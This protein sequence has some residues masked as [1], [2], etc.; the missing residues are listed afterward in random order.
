MLV[1]KQRNYA[2]A[3]AEH[4]DNLLI[5]FEPRVE[6]LTT[7]V[8]GIVSVFSD[9]QYRIHRQPVPSQSERFGDGGIDLEAVFGGKVAAHVL[10]GDLIGV[11]ETIRVRGSTRWLLGM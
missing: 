5:E 1:A 9:E 7:F 8:G 6:L 2:A 11:H 10:G 3:L 4:I